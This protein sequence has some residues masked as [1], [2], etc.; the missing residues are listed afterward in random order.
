MRHIVLS[1]FADEKIARGHSER[2][3]AFTQ[4]WSAYNRRMLSLIASA[5]AQAKKIVEARTHWRFWEW[6][7][8]KRA[9]RAFYQ[10]PAPRRPT[11]APPSEEE[12]RWRIGQEGESRILTAI[13]EVTP[14]VWVLVTGYMNAAGETDIL[15]VSPGGVAAIEVKNYSGQISCVGDEWRA[16][17]MVRG[18]LQTKPIQDKGGRPPNHQVNA[19]AERLEQFFARHAPSLEIGRVRRGVVFSH[20]RAIITTVERPSVNLVCVPAYFTPELFHRL[21]PERAK[22][23][24]TQQVVNLIRRDHAYHE[25]RKSNKG[26]TA[27]L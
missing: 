21:L 27:P 9:L 11:F 24:D 2:Q 1:D 4:D 3:T 6:W 25:R 22:P 14:P 7:K 10:Q 16:E 17:K 15:I 8:R 12:I 20:P 18:V 19:V 23:L 26:R 5:E 13:L